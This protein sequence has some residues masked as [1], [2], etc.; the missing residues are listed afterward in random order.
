MNDS[1]N[2]FLIHCCAFL[3][4]VS[5]FGLGMTS[6]LYAKEK[7]ARRIKVMMDWYP[8]AEAYASFLV[9]REKG[10]F[11]DE[12]LQVELVPGAGST[13]ST[14]LVA[15]K[16][17]DFGVADATT[18][19]IAR[20]KGAPLIV[21]AAVNQSTPVGVFFLKGTKVAGPRDLVG[22]KVS[23]D[24]KS[25][26]HNQ[27]LG[28]L[29]MNDIDPKQ[30]TFIPVTGGAEPIA[31]VNGQADVCLG[32]FCNTSAKLKRLGQDFNVMLFKD[33]GL[34]I[35]DY[36]IIT[37]ED[38]V[39]KNPEVVRGFMRAYVKGL[40][41]TLDHPEEAADIYLRYYPEGTHRE[42]EIMVLEN[43]SKFIENE[44][45]EEFGLGYQTL[46]GWERTQF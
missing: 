27:F 31:M 34:H 36:T 38:M 29:R 9:A 4:C 44:V 35:Y 43:I 12:G 3:A 42:T 40:R 14:K 2:R 8:Y 20:T 10:Y 18:T 33:N 21:L 39:R 32:V 13:V 11:L 45:T 30:I 19:L 23:S 22:K 17:S 1:H 5:I 46:Q 24:M 25:K 41:Y 16:E 28:F 6:S 7:S 26:K 37:H 15:N